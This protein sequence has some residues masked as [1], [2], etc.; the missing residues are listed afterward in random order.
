MKIADY[1]RITTFRLV[2][3]FG[4]IF[5]AAV[6]ALLS[7]VYW[8]TAGFMT[9]QI[10]LII[11]TEAAAFARESAEDLPETLDTYHTRDARHINLY[12]LFSHDGR[13]IT[14]NVVE[15]PAGLPQDGRVHVLEH[16]HLLGQLAGPVPAAR[17]MVVTLPWDEVLLVGRDITQLQ[18]IRG[19]ILTALIEAGALITLLGLATGFALSLRPLRRVQAIRA[20]SQRVAAG[21]LHIRLPVTPRH[22]EL[23]MLAATVNSMLTE[24]E[25]LLGEVKS[26]CDNIAHDLRTPMTRLRARLY[27]LQ[28]QFKGG[29]DAG[30]DM[31]DEA[32]ADTDAVLARFKALLRISEIEDSQRRGAFAPLACG[33]QLQQ[34]LELYQPLAEDQGKQLRLVVEKDATIEADAGLLFEAVANLVDNAIKFSPPGGEIVLCLFELDG[35]PCLDI[36]DRGPGIPAVESDIVLQ[37]FYRGE[38]AVHLEG[39]G[40]G[41]S[42][43]AAIVRLH[44]FSLRILDAAPGACVRIR[45]AADPFSRERN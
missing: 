24:V 25:R 7:L 40:L 23:D 36:L 14:G 15:L 26:V 9:Q 21:E 4:G 34:V 39:S 22:D 32:L 30:Q 3:L 42:I 12:G 45:L 11:V 44:G 2:L 37:R 8:R 28:Q 13:W 5:L 41:L 16:Y 38:Q 19:I 35:A 1:W 31:L 43:V 17:A 29:G 10:D 20:A 33:A 6:V 27:R 18:Q